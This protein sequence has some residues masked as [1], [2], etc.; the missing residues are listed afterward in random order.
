MTRSNATSSVLDKHVW[1][2]G[3]GLAFMNT[4]TVSRT[5]DMVSEPPHLALAE[6]VAV[7][8]KQLLALA[9]LGPVRKRGDGLAAEGADPVSHV[10]ILPTHDQHQLLD[11]RPSYGRRWSFLQ[12]R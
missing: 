4:T 5:S 6:H 9:H 10:G 2:I 7:E 1:Q 11:L 12:R 8:M 3:R